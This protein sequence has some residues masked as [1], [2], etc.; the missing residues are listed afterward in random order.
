MQPKG[1]QVYN[2]CIADSL[3]S[4]PTE[5]FTN[6]LLSDTFPNSSCHKYIPYYTMGQL[7]LFPVYTSLYPMSLCQAFP[8]HIIFKSVVIMILFQYLKHTVTPY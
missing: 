1:P 3:H 8:P 2:A 4:F 6:L 5:Q 7:F